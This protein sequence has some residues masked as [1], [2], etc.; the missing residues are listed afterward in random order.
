[1]ARDFKDIEVINEMEDFMKKQFL[2]DKEFMK[3]YDKTNYVY[4]LHQVY[5]KSISID[6]I[7][8]GTGI[9]FGEM[10]K[11]REELD[12]IASFQYKYTQPFTNYKKVYKEQMGDYYSNPAQ[13]KST[14]E[15]V[16]YHLRYNQE[17]LEY[18]EI[19]LEKT[20]RGY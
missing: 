3:T 18:I 11:R 19:V 2:E 8:L 7:A 20:Y 10:N 17:G 16:N 15:Y 4:P 14:K 6:G 5:K 13:D 1:M 9:D 12:S